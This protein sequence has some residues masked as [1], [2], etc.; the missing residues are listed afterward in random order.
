MCP[1]GGRLT[2]KFVKSS[3]GGASGRGGGGGGG[4]ALPCSPPLSSPFLFDTGEPALLHTAGCRAMQTHNMHT[5]KHTHSTIYTLVN[6]HTRVLRCQVCGLDQYTNVQPC[7]CTNMPTKI[8]RLLVFYFLVHTAFSFIGAKCNCSP[9]H[10]H[11]H[12]SWS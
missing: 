12:T 5:R 6:I 2:T 10:V 8:I 1:L 9:L 3:K 4:G 11:S 7:T